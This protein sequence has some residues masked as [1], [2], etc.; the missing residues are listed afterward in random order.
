MHESVQVTKDGVGDT[1][2]T[3]GSQPQKCLPNV[4]PDWFLPTPRTVPLYTA[5]QLAA[6]WYVR[7]CCQLISA[8]GL[9][10]QHCS[11]H[12]FSVTCFNL[13]KTSLWFSLLYKWGL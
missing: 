11:E 7:Q 6:T 13:L 4:T 1:G 5:H 8:R 12:S 10:Y 3:L 9:G 2:E